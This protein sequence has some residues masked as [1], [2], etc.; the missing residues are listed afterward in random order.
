[1][2]T[3]VFAETVHAV[4]AILHCL[5]LLGLVIFQVLDVL[6]GTGQAQLKVEDE[7][8][9]ESLWRRDLARI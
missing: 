1:M 6:K 5:K 2:L 7:I 4:I 9:A 8:L 3:Q